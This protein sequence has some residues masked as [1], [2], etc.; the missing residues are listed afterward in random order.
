MADLLN[1]SIPGLR[2][3]QKILPSEIIGYDGYVFG[4]TYYVEATN[5]DDSNPGTTPDKAFKTVDA[6]YDAMTTNNHDV[7]YL[8]GN[9]TH[10]LTEM[11]SF[12][13]NRCHF[14]GADFDGRRYGQAVKISLGATTAATD[15]ATLQNTG[16]RNSFMNIKFMNSNTVAEGIYCIADGG[17]YSVYRNCEIYKSTDLDVT[18]AS[19][20]L[21]NADSIQMFNCTIGS[22]ADALD[23][24]I[25]R[26][27]MLLTRVLSGKVTRDAYLEDVHFWRKCSNANNRMVYAAASADLER[28]MVMMRPVFNNA[29]LAAADPAQA[30]S[31]GAN[32][33]DGHIVAYYP[34]SSNVTKISTTTGVFVVGPANNAGA[35]LATQAA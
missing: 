2:Y 34:G 31:A 35:G 29:V 17:E 7:L 13:K 6:A 19:E 27:N 5:G 30:I 33:T 1:N 15:I 24:D 23:G 11:L 22:L 8:S 26:A 28:G 18:G 10:S 25:V 20:F 3:G 14:I 32:L 9:A 16:V 21:C 12:T 4:N